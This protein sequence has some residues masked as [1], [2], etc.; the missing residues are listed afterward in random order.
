[1]TSFT[2]AYLLRLAMWG[3]VAAALLGGPAWMSWRWW[4]RILPRASAEVRH[5]L[6]RAHFLVLLVLPLVVVGGFH[7]TLT[8]MGAE[9]SR[10]APRPQ[11]LATGYGQDAGWLALMIVAAWLVGALPA[12]LR[13]AADAWGLRRLRLRPAPAKL[14]E[15]V[16]LL[17]ERW[18][19]RGRLEVRVAKVSGPQVLGV[20]R[21]VLVVPPDLVRL[22]AAERKA[23]LLH[24]LAHVERRDFAANLCQRLALVVLWFQPAAW[25]LYRHIC[26]EREVCCDR[27]ALR[28]DASATALARALVRLAENRC[29]RAPVAMT[30]AGQGDLGRRVNHLL[31][32]GAAEQ[33]PRSLCA[34]PLVVSAF[35]LSA[36]GGAG[37]SAADTETAD[38]YVASALGPVI[39]IQAHDPAGSFA[40]RVHRGRVVGASVKDRQVP[41]ADVRQQGD[42]VTLLGTSKEPVVSFRVTPHGRIAWQARAAKS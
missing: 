17:D 15:E 13:L 27:L 23:I 28:H 19:R 37:L 8:G 38:L 21:P 10:G 3:L 18:S 24:E 20:T 14:V 9:V 26:R 12:A 34:W 40:V 22:P 6:A 42:R 35:I 5:R 30:M 7:L 1:M 2:A 39:S 29:T 32:P 36:L 31:A 4:G 11:A 33:S 41:Q 25:A 16:R